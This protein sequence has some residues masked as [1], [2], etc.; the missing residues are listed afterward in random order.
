MLFL[1]YYNYTKMLFNIKYI[2][3]I[4]KIEEETIARKQGHISL[5]TTIPKTYVKILNIKTGDNI[6]W[7]LDTTTKKIELKVIDQHSF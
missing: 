2:T 5:V 3:I 4:M 1:N 7:T 6:K